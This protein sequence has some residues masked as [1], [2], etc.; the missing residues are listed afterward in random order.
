MLSSGCHITSGGLA[1]G[2]G[3]TAVVAGYKLSFPHK[4]FCGLTPP[5]APNRSL[6]AVHAICFFFLIQLLFSNFYFS[7]FVFT[8]RL[9]FVGGGWAKP[10]N[11]VAIFWRGVDIAV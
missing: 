2:G 6:Y 9:Y 5:L 10:N 3:L 8:I 1:K 7:I 4:T 11:G